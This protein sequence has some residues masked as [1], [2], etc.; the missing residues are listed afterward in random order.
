MLLHVHQFMHQYGYGGIFLILFLEMVGIPFPAE[1][2]L[3]LSGIEWINGAFSLIPLILIA[4]LGNVMGSSIAY[5]I[6]RFLGRNVI[7]RYGKFVGITDKKLAA[8]EAKF[9]QYQIKALLVC[10]FI[11]GIR[12]LIP[13]LAGLNRMPFLIFTVYNTFVALIWTTLFIVFGRYIGALWHHYHHYLHGNPYF[14]VLLGVLF[15]GLYLTVKKKKVKVI[16]S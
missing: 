2:T 15:V 7:L 5:A 3:T 1:T 6:G 16:H 13:Y 10:K 11:A 9:Q 12:I 8:A 4:T 14:V